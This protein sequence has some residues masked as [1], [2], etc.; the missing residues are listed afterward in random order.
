[1]TAPVAP[2]KLT[3]IGVARF[4]KGYWHKHSMLSRLKDTVHALSR[5]M[6]HIGI[7]VIGPTDTYFPKGLYTYTHMY[8]QARTFRIE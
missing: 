3:H 5:V 4:A 6:D 7:L 2:P 1:M 8:R